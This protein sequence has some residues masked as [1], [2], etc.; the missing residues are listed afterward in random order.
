[1]E[2]SS[3]REQILAAAAA[4]VHVALFAFNLAFWG[5]EGMPQDRCG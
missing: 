5:F 1:M 4:G 2:W 3:K